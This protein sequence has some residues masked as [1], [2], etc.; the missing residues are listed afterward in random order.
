[1]PRKERKAF[2]EIPKRREK[3]LRAK[4][5]SHFL[6]ATRGIASTTTSSETEACGLFGGASF[7][8]LP[9]SHRNRT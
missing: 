3:E 9:W 8:M 2:S 4:H 1:M 6:A 5:A 7:Q